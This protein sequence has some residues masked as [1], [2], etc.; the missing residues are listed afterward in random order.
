MLS[1]LFASRQRPFI[2]RRHERETIAIDLSGSRLTFSAPPNICQDSFADASQEPPSRV[3]LFDNSKYSVDS[4]FEEWERE[5]V[6]LQILMK[7]S[8]ELFGP[9]WRGR[10][11]AT[12]DFTL[13]LYRH[14]AMPKDMNC[15]NPQH[16]ETVV[17]RHLY[18]WGPC[19]LVDREQ[20]APVNWQLRSQDGAT[21]IF[22]ENHQRFSPEALEECP[23]YDTH[24]SSCFF[25]PLDQTHYL[26]FNF[27]NLGYAPVEPCIRAMNGVRDL[28]CDSVELHLS[29]DA[30]AQLAS[31]QK[32]WPEAKANPTRSIEHWVY[33]EWHWG[34]KFDEKI[35]ITKPGSPPPP[36]QGQVV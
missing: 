8:W 13:M 20:K 32:Q 23:F 35:I 34:G 16:F 28:L 14:D 10:P 27:R 30:K 21:A 11:I 6:A 7:R 5:G 19:H 17:M 36:W 29:A 33:P 1:R 12:I 25:V 26:K 4:G 22:F 15:L 2:P 3:N 31:A 24:F 9:I 18:Y